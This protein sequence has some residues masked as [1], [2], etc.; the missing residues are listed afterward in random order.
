MK[1]ILIVDDQPDI[2]NLVEV[3]LKANDY[4]IL[5]AEDGERAIEIARLEKP[6][7]I[8]MDIMM[9]GEIDGLEATR[10][11]KNDLET[12]ACSIIILTGIGQL[13]ER[14]KALAGGAHAYL[15]KPFSPR[16]LICR[17]QKTFGQGKDER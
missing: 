5:Q 1:K 8:I 13:E 9:P 4:R 16:E 17:V 11:L 7:L 2:R 10:I 15:A 6:D 12:K 3:T 14:E